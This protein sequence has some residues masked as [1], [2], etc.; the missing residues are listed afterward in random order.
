MKRIRLFDED[1]PAHW[2]MTINYNGDDSEKKY[3]WINTVS[4]ES[5][6]K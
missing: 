1:F 6:E 3:A 5:V 4:A 2:G